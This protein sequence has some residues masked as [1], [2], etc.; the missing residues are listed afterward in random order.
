MLNDE[1]NVDARE[2]FLKRKEID[3]VLFEKQAEV[4]LL[5]K[6][7][8]SEA[9]QEDSKSAEAPKEKEDP[10]EP[11]TI[12]ITPVASGDKVE[13][14][15]SEAPQEKVV[16]SETS[17]EKLKKEIE[18]AGVLLGFLDS[19]FASTSV[20]IPTD[21][22]CSC[23]LTLSLLTPPQKKQTG[24][25][26][27]RIVHHLRTSLVTFPTWMSRGN[28]GSYERANYGV[29]SSRWLL[30]DFFSSNL[31]PFSLFCILT[32]FLSQ[33]LYLVT[34]RF[35]RCLEKDSYGLGHVMRNP[36]STSKFPSSRE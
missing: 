18:H 10:V 16:K 3:A 27:R 1:P 23:P 19:H 31:P 26:P 14:T 12:D 6:A 29:P 11:G 36:G 17:I 34:D 33:T 5:E 7:D 13:S 15:E 25:S 4:A 21:T 8:N 28:N 32:P 22:H 20:L 2:F 30:Y 24:P 9:P 35:S